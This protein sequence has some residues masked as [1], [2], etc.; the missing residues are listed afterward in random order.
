M[1]ER[2][3]PARTAYSP[4]MGLNLTGTGVWS[5]ELRSEPDRGAVADAVAELEELGYSA[6]WYPA[7]GDQRGAFDAAS[8]LLRASSTATVATGIL[9][10]WVADP[11]FVA[12]ERSELHDAFDGRFLLGL[13]VSHEAIVG[14][15]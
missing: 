8:D 5:R 4:G 9:S 10:V 15:E 6:L 12:A 3:P 2:W 13:G 7:G 1:A 11:E 14:S